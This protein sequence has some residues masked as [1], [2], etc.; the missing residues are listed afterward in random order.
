M[1]LIE[2]ENI[3]YFYDIKLSVNNIDNIYRMIRNEHL[4]YNVSYLLYGYNFF[5]VYNNNSYEIDVY[6]SII[7]KNVHKNVDLLLLINHISR[8]L[9]MS[10]FLTNYTIVKIVSD[11]LNH[12]NQNRICKNFKTIGKVSRFHFNHDSVMILYNN[13][14]S[15]TSNTY[16][17]IKKIYNHV[18]L[19][20]LLPDIL[21]TLYKDKTSLF[22]YIPFDMINDIITHFSFSIRFS[23]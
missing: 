16:N 21:V 10:G 2:F 8:L 7:I 1:V 3:N 11:D 23:I 22:H 4:F 13:K 12:F 14:L 20:L 15:I 18:Y 17:N 5:V 9:K 19:Y 6:K